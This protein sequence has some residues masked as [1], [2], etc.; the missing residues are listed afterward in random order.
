MMRAEA[1]AAGLT[2]P[3]LGL[4]FFRLRIIQALF[5]FTGPPIRVMVEVQPPQALYG[6]HLGRG[7]AP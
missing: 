4:L 1:S 3:R 5:E 6:E 7:M 2:C